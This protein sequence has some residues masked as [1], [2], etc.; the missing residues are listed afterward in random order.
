MIFI[1][2]VIVGRIVIWKFRG[3]RSRPQEFGAAVLAP[4][5][6]KRPQWNHAILEIDRALLTDRALS[7]SADGA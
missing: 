6:A 2:S 3:G 4:D 7:S 1:I 5:L